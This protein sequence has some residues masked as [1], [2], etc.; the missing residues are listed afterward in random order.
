MDNSKKKNITSDDENNTIFLKIF[1]N[2]D[3][4]ENAVLGRNCLLNVLK[5]LA[6][7]AEGETLK[8]LNQHENVKNALL[9]QQ[10][11]QITKEEEEPFEEKSAL[12]LVSEPE[13]N[14]V[15][16]KF[17]NA[18]EKIIQNFK[19]IKKPSTEQ[20]IEAIEDFIDKATYLSLSE[21]Y[22]Y[23]ICSKTLMTGLWKAEFLEKNT[24]DGT[25]FLSE[26]KKIEV[27]ML[28][29]D[30]TTIKTINNH[31][32]GDLQC[33]IY[34]FPYKNPPGH[35]SMFVILPDKISTAKELNE[36]IIPNMS[37]V[38]KNMNENGRNEVYFNIYMPKFK[39]K[40]QYNLDETMKKIPELN[41]LFE[42]GS[43]Y[44]GMFEENCDIGKGMENVHL[45]NIVEINNDEKGTTIEAE[46][47]CCM[48]DGCG[49][50][51]DLN[52][53]FVFCICNENTN[54]ILYVGILTNP[55][56]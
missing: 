27:P 6:L 32:F 31:K 14:H 34:R 13:I 17:K 33:N 26:N 44:H 49:N 24:R 18:V 21:Y 47:Y 16:E 7:G 54:E 46:A 42:R 52:R 53:P 29:R 45:E 25:F 3:N 56:G 4:H 19:I 37:N 10:Q 23:I 38:I 9:Q 35:Y 28:N 22:K 1:E 2:L 36:N 12:F 39:F 8:K 48:V 5:M 20:E 51:I 30:L 50:Y 40:K 41:F 55:L 11:Q 43:N 15:G